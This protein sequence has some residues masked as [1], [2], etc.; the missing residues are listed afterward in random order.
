M[1]SYAFKS[2]LCNMFEK[3]KNKTGNP[4]IHQYTSEIMDIPIYQWSNA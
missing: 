4:N 1:Q 2:G 3:Q